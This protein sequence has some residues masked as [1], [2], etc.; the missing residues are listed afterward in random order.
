MVFF[1][2]I[3]FSILPNTFDLSVRGNIE[4][5]EEYFCISHNTQ[6]CLSNQIDSLKINLSILGNNKARK[7]SKYLKRKQITRHFAICCASC[8]N[9][10]NH[11]KFVGI[12]ANV[13]N[14]I[15]YVD[16]HPN[17]LR[18]PPAVYYM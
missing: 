1:I 16:L 14:F 18:A 6:K 10:N 13:D 17:S 4:N 12:N 5:T 15:L 11:F 8:L 7:L 3:L 9:S 2:Y